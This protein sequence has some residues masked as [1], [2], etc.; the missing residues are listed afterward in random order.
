MNL[1]ILLGGLIGFVASILSM[2]VNHFLEMKKANKEREWKLEDDYF[3]TEKEV[4]IR[5]INQINSEIDKVI[6]CCDN[7]M[8]D[9]FSIIGLNSSKKMKLLYPLW[10]SG[11]ILTLSKIFQD[12]ELESKVMGFVVSAHELSDLLF[13]VDFVQIS[14]EEMI[15]KGRQVV[16]ITKK[17]YTNYTE[18]I[19]L[20]DQKLMQLKAA[21][22][23]H[24]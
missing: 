18:I 4:L 20:L 13:E 16:D 19:K 15:I 5:R 24:K 21:K 1:D 3:G 2:V 9:S 22:S 6:V 17:V 12:E 10:F 8:Q 11:N 23:F 14:D 7:V